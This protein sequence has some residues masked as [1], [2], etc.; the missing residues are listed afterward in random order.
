M[1]KE[2]FA[3]SDRSTSSSI[4]NH[5]INSMNSG[6]RLLKR[7][8]MDDYLDSESFSTSTSDLHL[9]LVQK[10][11]KTDLMYSHRHR[12]DI[13]F[14]SCPCV[15]LLV[16]TPLRLICLESNV[17]QMQMLRGPTVVP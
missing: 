2:A 8:T 1:S 15:L 7:I 17:E 13:F 16:L 3:Y 12:K 10:N 11:C 9:Q 4:W 5:K 14:K 6:G